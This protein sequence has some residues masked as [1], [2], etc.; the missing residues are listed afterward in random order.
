MDKKKKINLEGNLFVL[1]ETDDE[2]TH[3]CA[4]IAGVDVWGILSQNQGEMVK[5]NF[6]V[7][8]ERK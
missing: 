5:L 7:L 6:E 4:E 1:V 3:I 2:G 8:N